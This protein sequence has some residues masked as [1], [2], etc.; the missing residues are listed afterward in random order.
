M[1]QQRTNSEGW[2][3]VQQGIHS[4]WNG[5]GGRGMWEGNVGGGRGIPNQEIAF[6]ACSKQCEVGGTMWAEQHR[7]SDSVCTS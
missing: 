4:L 1:S 7:L 6:S 3:L 2:T 5:N